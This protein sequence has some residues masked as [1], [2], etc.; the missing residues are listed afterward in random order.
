MSGPLSNLPPYS[1]PNRSLE[2]IAYPYHSQQAPLQL[3]NISLALP[4]KKRPVPYV[5][6]HL[7]QQRIGLNTVAMQSQPVLP[8]PAPL[9][10]QPA[11]T[12]TVPLL[13][14]P[15]VTDHRTASQIFQDNHT[16]LALNP[17][18]KTELNDPS[19]WPYQLLQ[20]PNHYL[21]P[22]DIGRI[23]GANSH[24]L[25]RKMV[26]EMQGGNH[27]THSHLANLNF[28][29]G[30]RAPNAPYLFGYIPSE[31]FMPGSQISRIGTAGQATNTRN[32]RL[33]ED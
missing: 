11:A 9:P 23:T 2:Q 29:Y 32:K 19:R 27:G 10:I 12:Q 13:P 8:L 16:Y 1:G 6:P 18:S 24:T 31:E 15:P 14:P 30:R 28:D 7:Q 17:A 3:N 5:V 4:F 21:L 26:A 25:S 33:H 20:R 22:S